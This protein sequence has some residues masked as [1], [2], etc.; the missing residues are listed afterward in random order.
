MVGKRLAPVS[1]GSAGATRPPAG[2]W[3]GTRAVALAEDCVVSAL[4]SRR[5]VRIALTP[6]LQLEGGLW[7]GAAVAFELVHPRRG[8]LPPQL[9]SAAVQQAGLELL[10]FHRVVARTISLQRQF[11]AHG[12]RLPTSVPV[13]PHVFAGAAM[14]ESLERRMN[15][16][17]LSP[18][19]L[20]LDVLL[21]REANTSRIAA[22]PQQ[23]RAAD[24]MTPRM[25]ALIEASLQRVNA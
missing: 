1:S 23:E 8:L 24:G 10:L 14:R 25:L 21:E 6:Q 7:T 22:N 16:F 11:H 4:M 12:I 2:R 15:A 18:E 13:P 5:G 9:V 20:R 17:G 19:L 3:R